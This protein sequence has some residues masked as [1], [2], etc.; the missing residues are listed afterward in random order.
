MSVQRTYS[1]T[2][3]AEGWSEGGGGVPSVETLPS[4]EWHN[5]EARFEPWALGIGHGHGPAPMRQCEISAIVNAC[6][7]D[8]QIRLRLP[9]T[10]PCRALPWPPRLWAC[11]FHGNH[12]FRDILGGERKRGARDTNQMQADG[13]QV[14]NSIVHVNVSEP[15][16][17]KAQRDPSFRNARNS[18]VLCHDKH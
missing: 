2:G 17:G 9:T 14:G 12:C 8:H 4:R 1:S 7:G 15:S 3:G 13:L 6:A 16:K 11:T 18:L 10:L 5:N